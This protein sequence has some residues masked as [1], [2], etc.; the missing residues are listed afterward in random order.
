MGLGKGDGDIKY[1]VHEKY[2]SDLESADVHIIENVTEYQLERYF[3]LYFNPDGSTGWD[4]RVCRIDPRVFGFACARPR[5]FGVM[6]KTA[7]IG[8]WN[9]NFEFVEVLNSLRAQPTMGV[10]DFYY[11]KLDPMPLS[12]G[13]VFQ[14]N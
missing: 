10:R 5:V 7:Y 4:F 9:P 3:N 12:Q 6:W 1:K 14:L 8:L 13:E 11:M 2:Y